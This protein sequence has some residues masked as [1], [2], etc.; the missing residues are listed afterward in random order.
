M[1]P[2]DRLCIALAEKLEGEKK[3]ATDT[4]PTLQQKPTQYNLSAFGTLDDVLILAGIPS[5]EVRQTYAELLSENGLETPKLLTAVSGDSTVL[6]QM[7][8]KFGH[9]V[10]L[11]KL[12]MK[13]VEDV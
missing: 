4:D 2:V 3:Q 9:A 8:M 12:L 13:F 7:G 11:A 10:A 5:A 6:Q 1:K